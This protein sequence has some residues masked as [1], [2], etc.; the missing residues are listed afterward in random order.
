MPS[1]VIS[2]RWVLR[3]PRT[4]HMVLLS[5]VLLGPPAKLWSLFLCVEAL[6]T[7]SVL[8]PGPG[9]VSMAYHMQAM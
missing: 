9:W 3:A 4:F 1:Y 5:P 2:L 7:A 6:L 8:C